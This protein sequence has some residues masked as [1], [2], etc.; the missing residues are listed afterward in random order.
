MEWVT[1]KRVS[2]SASIHRNGYQGSCTLSAIVSGLSHH[3]TYS[4]FD[5]E[6]G[7]AMLPDGEY[8]VV[9]G[10]RAVRFRKSGNDWEW[11][12]SSS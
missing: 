2:L 7:D 6:N 12:R 3:P 11:V 4:Q 10:M 1:T 8:I 9:F 5:I